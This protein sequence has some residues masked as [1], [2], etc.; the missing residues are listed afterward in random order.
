M[1]NA[2]RF[3]DVPHFL[4][5]TQK[6]WPGYSHSAQLPSLRNYWRKDATR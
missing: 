1:S 2:G 3:P 4:L 5:F 6:D